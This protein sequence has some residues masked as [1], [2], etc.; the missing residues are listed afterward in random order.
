MHAIARINAE[1]EAYPFASAKRVDFINTKINGKDVKLVRVKQTVDRHVEVT[2]AQHVV[3]GDVKFRATI[4]ATFNSEALSDRCVIVF[5][6]LLDDGAYAHKRF[7]Q[8][9]ASMN[10]YSMLEM[11]SKAFD[12]LLVE[13]KS[14]D[15]RNRNRIVSVIKESVKDTFGSSCKF[16]RV[17][18][19]GLTC[20]VKFIMTFP[21]QNK[22]PIKRIV[23]MFIKLDNR[24]RT[25]TIGYP[26][27]RPSRTIHLDSDLNGSLDLNLGNLSPSDVSLI[28]HAIS[29]SK[30]EYDKACSIANAVTARVATEVAV[31]GLK[32]VAH[33]LRKT[34]KIAGVDFKAQSI[35]P[36]STFSHFSVL[37]YGYKSFGIH[38]TVE[39]WPLLDEHDRVVDYAIASRCHDDDNH[40]F[41]IGP[42]SEIEGRRPTENDIIKNVEA[43]IAMDQVFFGAEFSGLIVASATPALQV[44]ASKLATAR[45]AAESPMFFDKKSAPK[46]FTVDDQVFKL[47]SSKDSAKYESDKYEVHVHFED[48]KCRAL[49]VV[50]RCKR[51]FYKKS[52]QGNNVK[53][54]TVAPIYEFPIKI[55]DLADLIGLC[56]ERIKL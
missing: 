12:E 31:P 26:G 28:V 44:I 22:N 42:Y 43:L 56:I 9:M 39:L 47:T 23:N 35:K 55:S 30:K 34:I 10:R 45:I 32:E 19:S 36:H 29:E 38:I 54:T 5:S 48:T 49:A 40:S 52:S 11:S 4:Y 53:P 41:V 18:G 16:D 15:N 21:R 2:Y 25:F 20:G 24:R 17:I 46:S 7:K 51:D 3:D 8:S 50:S 13:V 27:Y 1:K 6:I 37:A 33:L 14:T